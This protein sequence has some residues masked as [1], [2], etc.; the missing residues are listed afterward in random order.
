M[1]EFQATFVHYY[2]RLQVKAYKSARA[3]SLQDIFLQVLSWQDCLSFLESFLHAL[4]MLLS[5]FQIKF[6]F[7]SDITYLSSAGADGDP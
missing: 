4:Y 3:L 1:S 2:C 7:K 6:H 5:E